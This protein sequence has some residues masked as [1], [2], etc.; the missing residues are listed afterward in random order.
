MRVKSSTYGW[1]T[2]F[3]T[4]SKLT[5]ILCELKWFDGS[6]TFRGAL[7]STRCRI[8]WTT[9]F[10]ESVQIYHE[11][12]FIFFHKCSTRAYAYF[13]ELQS[14]NVS[15]DHFGHLVIRIALSLWMLLL[16]RFFFCLNTHV[17]SDVDVLF[18]KRK[19]TTLLFVSSIRQTRD[20]NSLFTLQQPSGDC[21]SFAQQQ[22]WRV[23]FLYTE[24]KIEKIEN[25]LCSSCS[26]TSEK[27]LSS[28][29]NNSV[30]KYFLYWNV[31]FSNAIDQLKQNV[32]KL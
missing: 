26:T 11:P 5:L 1:E 3:G 18:E 22:R 24:R 28:K 23:Y 2:T 14:R 16:T 30:V 32:I 17:S 29:N 10:D 6:A 31:R 20:L 15:W 13:W 4:E 12:T 9:W 25:K 21:V 7:P 19:R 8:L 27:A